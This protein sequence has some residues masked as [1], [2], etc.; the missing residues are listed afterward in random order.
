MYMCVYVYVG[1]IVCMEVSHEGAPRVVV[2]VVL[3]VLVV[4]VVVVVVGSSSSSSSSRD[5]GG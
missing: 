3:V 1:C 4:V 2:L 5:R